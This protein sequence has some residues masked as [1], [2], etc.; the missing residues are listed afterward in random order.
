MAATSC[1]FGFASH[2]LAFWLHPVVYNTN[3][4]S[5][6][7]Q[8][9]FPTTAWVQYGWLLTLFS[10]RGWTFGETTLTWVSILAVW[11]FHGTMSPLLMARLSERLFL[12]WHLHH[13]QMPVTTRGNYHTFSSSLLAWCTD[14]T[15][16]HM[17]QNKQSTFWIL[18]CCCLLFAEF[19]NFMEEY[20]EQL[21]P[22]IRGIQS[23][24]LYKH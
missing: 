18:F 1:L 15:H 21:K 7:C 19:C 3:W 20:T 9:S 13:A 22:S 6:R 16:T 24:A 4:I 11:G 8:S 12:R 10:L 14:N 17:Q 5:L 23:N 2:H